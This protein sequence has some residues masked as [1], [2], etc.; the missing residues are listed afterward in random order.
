MRYATFILF[1]AL[2]TPLL[3][4]AQIFTQQVKTP[5]TI[6]VEG[7]VYDEVSGAPL[8][9]ARVTVF[10]DM[11]IASLAQTET[12]ASGAYSIKV[13]KVSRYKV[14]AEKATYFDA[15]IVVTH[16][17]GTMQV[18][19]GLGRKPG[20]VFDITIFDKAYEHNP[21]N[22]LRD[23]KVEIYNNTTAEQVLT[24][25]RLQ[26]STFNFSFAEGNH[27][28][29]LVRKQGYLNRRI[30]VYVN[31]NGCILCVDGM[32]IKEPD[33]VPLM[34]HNNEI[35]H[36]LGTIDLDSITIGKRFQLNNIYYD[37]D[38]WAIR[39][40][41]A[42]TLDKLAVFL[43][44][45]P[46][47]TV[48]LGS[49][50]DARGSDDYNLLLSDKRAASAVEYLLTEQGIDTE[51][52]TSKGYGETQLVNRCDDGQSCSETEHQLNRRTEIKITGIVAED[53]LWKKSLKQIIED[54]SLYKKV[55]EQEK[56]E[57]TFSSQSK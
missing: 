46:G 18:D 24:I 38:K 25:E 57:R 12:D 7:K 17:D 11:M 50:T 1:I 48:E 23:C 15:E 56:R 8:N 36:F 10:D 47:I 2:M 21:I 37:F 27:Y 13:P 52:I 44:D 55:L 54:K 9:Q 42:S 41:A 6:L 28:T 32:G 20:Y 51:K 3:L 29:V 4:T 49:H 33:L 16:L 45:N 40:E 31:V 43:K 22:T 19:L 53:P 26:K 35:G 34:T 5:E 14:L 39:P 30:E